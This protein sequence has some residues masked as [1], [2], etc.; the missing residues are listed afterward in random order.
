[1]ANSKVFNTSSFING[2]VVSLFS[3][4]LAYFVPVNLLVTEALCQTLLCWPMG[5]EM[6]KEQIDYITLTTK[7][8]LKQ[9]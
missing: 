6:R 5:A 4:E 1:M 8:I 7:N 9:E 3:S 2:P